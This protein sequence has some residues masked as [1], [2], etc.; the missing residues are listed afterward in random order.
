MTKPRIRVKAW[1]RPATADVVRLDMVTSL[2]VPA[3]LVLAAAMESDLSEV[4]ILGYSPQGEYFAASSPDGADVLWLLERCK[5]RLLNIVDE[6]E[7]RAPVPG[8]G[9]V[10]PFPGREP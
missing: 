9:D 4:V 2:D 5:R 6:I 7:P 8:G 3:A 10:I 1:S